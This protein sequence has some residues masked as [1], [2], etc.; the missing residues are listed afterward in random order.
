MPNDMQSETAVPFGRSFL[1][2]LDQTVGDYK[3][4]ADRVMIQYVVLRIGLIVAS[5]SLPALTTIVDRKWSAIAAIAVAILAGLDTQFNWG[6]EWRH[7]RSA[8]LGLE[9]IVRRYYH[10]EAALADGRTIGNIRTSTENFDKL[11]ADAE[12]FMETERES[13]FK[14]RLTERK[15]T[16]RTR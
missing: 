3:A 8:Q 5:A 10:G 16:R 11:Y 4:L 1:H 2:L 12:E 6:E 9:R 14:F 13:F 15:A 7:Y